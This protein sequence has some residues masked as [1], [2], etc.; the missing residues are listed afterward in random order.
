MNPVECRELL[1]EA[2]VL[3][4]VSSPEHR[5]LGGI[6]SDHPELYAEMLAAPVDQLAELGRRRYERFGI[7]IEPYIF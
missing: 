1:Q 5:A 3:V 4:E 7:E 6:Y 2:V